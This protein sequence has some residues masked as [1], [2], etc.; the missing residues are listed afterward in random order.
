VVRGALHDA[1]NPD[2]TT[3]GDGLILVPEFKLPS[4]RVAFS[5]RGPIYPSLHPYAD[6]VL[7][8]VCRAIL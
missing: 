3:V 1:M 2:G 7:A 5:I 8:M 4:W 6:E